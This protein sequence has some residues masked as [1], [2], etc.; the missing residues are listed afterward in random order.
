[1]PFAGLE[2][3]LLALAFHVVQRARSDYEHLEIGEYE[4]RVDSREARHR[5]QFVATGPGRA[6][7]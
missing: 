3:A 7:S 1:M 4:V 2:V 6:W 5:I